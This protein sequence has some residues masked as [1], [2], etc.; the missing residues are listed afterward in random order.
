MS[1]D[2]TDATDDRVA[3]RR[4]VI[5][6]FQCLGTG[7]QLIKEQYW[8]FLGI[9]VVGVLIASFVPLG[10]LL[11]PMMCGIY[12][13]L[14]RQFRG[15][16]VKFEMLFRGFDDFAQSLIATL[17]M[18]VPLIAILVPVYILLIVGMVAGMPKPAPGG[19]PPAGPG[20]GFFAALGAFYVV[21]L[22]V[23]I[24]VQVFFFFTYPLIADKKLS[25]VQA[26]G[27]SFRAAMGNFGGVLGLVALIFL[28]NIAGTFACCVGS[29][30]VM[31]I[32]YAAFA[33]AYQKVFGEDET[34]RPPEPPEAADYGEPDEP[35]AT[36]EPG[37]A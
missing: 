10:I 17:L 26:V 5:R 34:P 2:R 23:S 6:P 14:L 8:L 11:G 7:F 15:R 21:V 20:G 16:S 1:D 29:F 28:L 24:L 32:H 36:P 30:F 19:P 33:V 3:F 13:C 25:G 4:G 37:R 18:L 27:T 9:T 22:V 35:P 12:Y 31:P